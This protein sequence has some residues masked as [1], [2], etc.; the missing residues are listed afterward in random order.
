MS[1]SGVDNVA[2][3][4]CTKDKGE[5]RAGEPLCFACANP[6][7][8]RDWIQSYSSKVVT[9]RELRVS[10]V[11][12]ADIPHALAQ[13]VRFNGHLRAM[14]Y[15]VAQHCV[16]GAEQIAGPFK[17]AFLLHEV[18]EVYLPDIPA[19]LKPFVKVQMPD[20]FN[21]SGLLTWA[22]LEALHADVIFEAIGL[23]SLRHLIDTQEVREMDVQMLMTE[24]RD[25]ASPEPEP[26]GID[27]EPL[28]LIIDRC[29]DAVEAERRFFAAFAG[30]TSR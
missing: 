25:L 17:L 10:Q 30:L 5:S 6:A 4:K 8:R 19:P 24:K 29:W 22:Q 26:W 14:T 12:L 16:M 9:P 20:D 23:G 28:P 3:Q 11:T 2:C 21:G 15:S 13:K 18:S 1:P 7:R 27:V